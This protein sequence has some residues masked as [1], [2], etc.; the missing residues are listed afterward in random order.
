LAELIS[1]FVDS[2]LR[3]RATAVAAVA[4]LGRL[5]VPALLDVLAADDADLARVAVVTLGK[6]GPVAAQAEGR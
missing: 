3:V 6:M 4:G 5:A 2:D 1:L